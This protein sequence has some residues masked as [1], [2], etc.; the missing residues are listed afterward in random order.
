MV[1]V[2]RGSGRGSIAENTSKAIRAALV[3]GAE[4]VE[5]DIIESTDGEFFLF[6]DGYEPMSFGIEQRLPQLSTAEIEALNYS[7]CISEPGGYPVEK[8]DDVLAEFPTTFFNVDRSWRW[9]PGLLDRMAAKGNIS[10]LVVKCP[11]LP[12]ALGALSQHPAPF[13]F[14]PIVR[15][16]AEVE[17]VIADENLNTVGFELLAGDLAHPFADRHYIARL[18]ERGFVV[19]LN[20]LN[21]GDRVPLFAGFDDETSLLIDPARGWGELAD[22]GADI[23]QT[24]WPGPLR[25][26][27]ASCGQ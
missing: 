4:M 11:M 22:R 23:I 16:P 20:A 26:Y 21:L 18:R 19:L 25:A 13:P 15:T 12:D 2:H 27:L 24:D 1:A 14:I 5:I 9:W 10:H 17:E 6:H 7:W 8:L 3:E